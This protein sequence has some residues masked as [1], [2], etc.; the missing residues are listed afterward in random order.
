MCWTTT[1]IHQIQVEKLL[2]NEDGS[3]EGHKSR[4]HLSTN[5]ITPWTLLMTSRYLLQEITTSSF[6]SVP[7]EYTTILIL[8]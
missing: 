1:T 3:L 2:E 7:K 8:G 4:N 5:T 6:E